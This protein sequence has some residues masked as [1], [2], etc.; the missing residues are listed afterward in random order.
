MTTKEIIN[1]SLAMPAGSD[2]LVAELNRFSMRSRE[3]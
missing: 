3:K 1:G 2:R